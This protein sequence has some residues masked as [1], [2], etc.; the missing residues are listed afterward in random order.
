M[1]LDLV[2]RLG[3]RPIVV[4]ATSG[5]ELDNLGAR[6]WFADA[7]VVPGAVVHLGASIGVEEDDPEGG[8]RLAATRRAMT[9]LDGTASSAMAGALAAANLTLTPSCDAWIG[10][11]EVFSA[12]GAPLLS[13]SGAGLDFHTPED[14]PDRATS[15][16]AMLR[17][18][19]R[20]RTLEKS[21]CINSLS[22]SRVSFFM[23]ASRSRWFSL[24]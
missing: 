3:D 4:V 12:F 21:R 22:S 7:S 24:R 8:R 18:N 19:S 11:G 17:V 6:R 14:L 5:H 16:V 1:L 9:N 20:L 13:L 15:P 23:W 10:E 2:A